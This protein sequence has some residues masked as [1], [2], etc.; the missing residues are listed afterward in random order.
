M[1]V[2]FQNTVNHDLEI[3]LPQ[4]PPQVIFPQAAFYA[5]KKSLAFKDAIGAVCGE[6]ITFYPPGIPIIC[7][8]EEITI[9]IYE[10]CQKMVQAG[11]KVVGPVDCK[12]EQIRVVK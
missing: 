10:Y 12:L 2:K 11:Y 1:A 3:K 6:T 8:G 7:P 5:S 9:D 4:I